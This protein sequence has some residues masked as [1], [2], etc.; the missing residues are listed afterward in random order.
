MKKLYILS[1]IFLLWAIPVFGANTHSIDLERGSGQYL[2]AA[3]S[4]SVSVEGDI[5]IEAWVKIDDDP[6]T[7]NLM[8]TVAG[9][10]NAADNEYAYWFAVSG[11][12]DA[13]N[14]GLTA[15][16][17][18]NFGVSL[19]DNHTH[20]LDIAIGT[21]THIAMVADVSVPTISFYADGVEADT[22]G[23]SGSSNFIEDM[24]GRFHIGRNLA[25]STRYFD[26][27]IDEVRLWND[28]RS[29]AEI[30]DN[31]NKEIT[32]SEGDL[33]GYWQLNDE[34]LDQTANDNDLTNVNSGT[35]GT[36]VPTWPPS[37]TCTCPEDGT[38]YYVNGSD[39]CYLS[40]N[41]D[42]DGG[43]LF[44]LGNGTFNIID[45]AILSVSGIHSTGTDIYVKAGSQINFK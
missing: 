18:D 43:E 22:H 12:H 37:D 35:F 42:L 38:D 24:D 20:D 41:C 40:T 17:W 33:A 36:D 29:E 11:V 32:G 16:Y 4:V 1:L 9:K 8:Y 26:G 27:L 45:N 21:W 44:L 6:A 3:D 39:N 30:N 25:G 5:T 34:L 31:M 15:A 10:A 13:E 7:S 14:V 28:V 23:T 19:S 2:W